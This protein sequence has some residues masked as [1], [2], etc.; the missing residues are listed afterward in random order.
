MLTEC[1][2]TKSTWDTNQK[3]HKEIA[4]VFH[5][6][7][8][9]TGTIEDLSK[10]SLTFFIRDENVRVVCAAYGIPLTEKEIFLSFITTKIGCRNKG[11]C[12]KLLKAIFKGQPMNFNRIILNADK[13][14][15]AV[16]TFYKK[17]HFSKM[18]K[19]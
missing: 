19:K 15:E 8:K 10:K 17:R 16:V 13:N 5:A 7:F 9:R 3:L 4:D 11:Y 14:D 2:E 1:R 6:S 18:G 12:T